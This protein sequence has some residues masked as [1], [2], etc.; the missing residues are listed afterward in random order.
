M[1]KRILIA[2]DNAGVRSLIRNYLEMQTEFDV[3]GEAADGV[4]AIEKIKELNPDLVLLDLA[5]PRMNGAE[6]ASIIKG[7]MPH[8]PIILFSVH[9]EKI[10]KALA[11]AVGVDAVLSKPDGIANLVESVRHLLGAA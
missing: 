8:L 3:C 9:G 5:M 11:S 1:P 6:A 2:D 10:G 4:D 7:S